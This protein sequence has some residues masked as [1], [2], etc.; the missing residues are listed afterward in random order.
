MIRTLLS[1]RVGL[2][3]PYCH[4]FLYPRDVRVSGVDQ[5]GFA[6]REIGGRTVFVLGRVTDRMSRLFREGSSTGGTPPTRR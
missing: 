5:G 2:V 4:P 3:G 6:W 1:L